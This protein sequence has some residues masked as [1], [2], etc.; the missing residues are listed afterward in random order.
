MFSLINI[1]FFSS[2]SSADVSV[3][4]PIHHWSYNIIDSFSSR[5]FVDSSGLITR[6]CSRLKMADLVKQIIDN[7]NNDEELIDFVYISMLEDDLDK[8]IEEFKYE[9]VILGVTVLQ[10]NDEP[11]AKTNFRVLDPFRLQKV[12]CNLSKNDEEYS[13]KN[14]RGRALYEGLNFRASVRTTGVIENFIAFSAEPVYYRNRQG[15]KALFEEIYL[16]LGFKNIEFNIGRNSLKWGAGYN[17]SLIMSDNVF[18]FDMLKISNSEPFKMSYIGNVN[19]IWFISELEKNRIMGNAK[20][21]GLRV[22][23]SPLSDLS[24]GFSNIVMLGGGNSGAYVG[25]RDSINILNVFESFFIPYKNN[26]DEKNNKQ[27]AGFDI[28]YKLNKFLLYG[29]TAFNQEDVSKI[30]Y[31]TGVYTSDIFSQSGLGLRLEYANSEDKN[32]NLYSHNVYQSGFTY[33]GD[34][35]GHYMGNDADDLLVRVEQKGLAENEAIAGVFYNKQRR[36]I[37][38]LR[39]EVRNNFGVDLILSRTNKLE[40]KFLYEYEKIK[41]YLNKKSNN[42]ENHIF[43]IRG[44][45]EI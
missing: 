15:A 38:F 23:I 25:S 12:F 33:K 44:T 34:I 16:K 14:Q 11:V 27:I 32:R 43:E 20:L 6:P 10:E 22:D 4:V 8:L 19:F 18:P 9:L 36:G 39:T 35:I 45:I 41:N 2:F 26:I 1:V 24:F 40:A 17:G 42:K 5:G 29:E 13:W 21:T 28:K 3:D 30:A 31:L 37:S 7:I